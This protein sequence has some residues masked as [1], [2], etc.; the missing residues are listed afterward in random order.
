[1]TQENLNKQIIITAILLIAVVLFFQFTNWDMSLQSYF[2]NF[3]GKSWIVDRKD[4]I[5]K[6]IFY[7]G[8]KKLFKIFSILILILVVISLFKK[9]NII[10]QYKKGLIIL[11]LSMILVPALTVSIKGVTNMPC[12]NNLTEYGGRYPDVRIFDSYPKDFIQKSK[13]KCWPAGHA[14]MGFSLMALFFLFKKPRNQKIALGIALVLAWMTGG[15]KMSIGD[16][17]LSHTLISMILGWLIILLIV[18]SI[19]L[20]EKVKFRKSTTI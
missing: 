18:K 14:S 12:P 7:D 1:M 13:I 19:S 4:S 2:Y 16:H 3:E 10:E 5:L 6:Y 8:F 11:L 9:I 20:L 15:Y 17:F